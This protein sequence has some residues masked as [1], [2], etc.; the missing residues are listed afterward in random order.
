MAR[1]V[2]ACLVAPNC[3]RKRAVVVLIASSF[4]HHLLPAHR[5]PRA[6]KACRRRTCSHTARLVN[7][8]PPIYRG[9]PRVWPHSPPSS[10]STLHLLPSSNGGLRLIP[11][12]KR[13]LIWWWIKASVHGCKDSTK[14]SFHYPKGV[15][16]MQR[17][18]KNNSFGESLGTHVAKNG[19]HSV[20]N[21]VL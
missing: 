11:Y 16:S 8:R 1:K 21:N 18:T 7:A 19:H 3:R 2:P 13:K 14:R 10:Q 4:T 5:L 15:V 12:R 9:I 20:A 6:V 17:R